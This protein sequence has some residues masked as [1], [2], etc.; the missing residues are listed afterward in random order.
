MS[1]NAEK[2]DRLYRNL[3][4]YVLVDDLDVELHFVKENVV[5]LQEQPLQR[6]AFARDSDGPGQ[7]LH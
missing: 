4:D 5:I 7:K 6:Q 2:T 1:G 3:K